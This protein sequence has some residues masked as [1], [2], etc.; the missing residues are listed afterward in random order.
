MYIFDK[1]KDMYVFDGNFERFLINLGVSQDHITKMQDKKLQTN[2]DCYQDFS[3]TGLSERDY[4]SLV[5]LDK[6]IGTSRGTVGWSVFDN[7]KKMYIGDRDPIRFENCFGYLNKMSLD[8]L[9]E[10]YQE[11]YYPVQMVYY[12]DDDVYYL[13]NDGNHRT[14]TAM[15]LGADKIKARV[16]NAHCD[17]IK[18]KK[19]E[20]GIEFEKKYCIERVLYNGNNVDIIFKDENGKYV[21]CGYQGK[22][23]EEDVYIFIDKLSTMIESDK[24]LVKKLKK[25]HK[26]IQ[27]IL[28]GNKFDRIKSYIEKEYIDDKNDSYNFPNRRIIY[29]E[30]L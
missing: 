23:Q 12:V 13:C 28:L 21:I 30:E 25:Y 6:V 27:K 26:S 2:R 18:R 22:K 5:P 3:K 9:K 14:L 11:L 29:W 16:T 7:V 20:A 4:I 17:F 8:E 24:L 1:K 19:Y 15:L 10:S